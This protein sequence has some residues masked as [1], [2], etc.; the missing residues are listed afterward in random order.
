MLV[1][2]AKLERTSKLKTRTNLTFS[3]K[4]ELDDLEIL[5]TI[6]MTGHLLFSGDEFKRQVEDAMKNRKIVVDEN[7]KT[8]SQIIRGLIWQL[9]DQNGMNGEDAYKRW[10][11]RE[12]A[13][14][15]EKLL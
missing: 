11:D 8:P 10:T 9:A 7:G 1:I 4:Q 12:I 6:G 15:R 5:Q 2:E 14:L 13:D 3:T